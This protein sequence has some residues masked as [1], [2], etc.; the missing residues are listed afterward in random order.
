[1]VAK[2]TLDSPSHK[3]AIEEFQPESLFIWN[4]KLK[5]IFIDS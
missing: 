4:F 3:K 5:N 1:M 2:F